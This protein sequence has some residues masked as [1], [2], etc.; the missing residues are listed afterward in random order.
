MRSNS[1]HSVFHWSDA[2]LRVVMLCFVML[3]TFDLV[4]EPSHAP[5]E[6]HSVEVVSSSGDH[7]SDPDVIKQLVDDDLIEFH[8]SFFEFIDLSADLMPIDQLAIS[9]FLETFSPPPEC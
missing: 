7:D 3:V 2:I 1:G 6:M 4:V 5:V 8:L 9:G